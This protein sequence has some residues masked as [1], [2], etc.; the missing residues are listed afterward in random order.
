MQYKMSQSVNTYQGTNYKSIFRALCGLSYVLQVIFWSALCGCSFS[1]LVRNALFA[2]IILFFVSRFVCYEHERKDS[3]FLI[4]VNFFLFV[5]SIAHYFWFSGLIVTDNDI[6][7]DVS[8]G[9]V[10]GAIENLY[11]LKNYGIN[12]IYFISKSGYLMQSAYVYLVFSLCGWYNLYAV[13]LFHCFFILISVVLF[14]RSLEN[15]FG[16]HY[17]YLSFPV[18]AFVFYPNTIALSAVLFKDSIVL[19][20]F[21]ILIYYLSQIYVQHDK[22]KYHCSIKLLM[23]G[24]IIGFALRPI[25]AFFA[26]FILL[27]GINKRKK[28]QLLLVS[29]FIILVYMLIFSPTL[30]DFFSTKGVFVRNS[31]EFRTF[32]EQSVTK[33]L[34]LAPFIERWY[35]LPLQ[36]LAV[37]VA[38][39]PKFFLDNVSNI[40]E[41]F[42]ALVNVCVLPLVAI[43]A[44]FSIKESKYVNTAWIFLL[45]LMFVILTLI[46]I[47]GL[48]SQRYQLAIVPIYI[49]LAIKALKSSGLYK[50]ISFYIIYFILLVMS[51]VIYIL[52][53][54]YFL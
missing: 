53:K 23:S 45:Y 8:N 15:F 36:M 33:A 41:S 17:G 26:L 4:F 32:S 28:I 16:N 51:Y 25:Y 10:I 38:P 47:F 2:S 19:T 11:I 3:S 34:F 5:F 37:Y 21:I 44:K 13:F 35:T 43:G 24:F 40:G 30:T 48:V 18:L 39:F 46:S 20:L 31:N 27:C 50:I 54:Q 42:S 49:L 52:Y 6:S 9:D 29:I 1:M 12:S 7:R 14:R 22:I